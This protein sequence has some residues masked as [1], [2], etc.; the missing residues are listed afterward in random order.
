MNRRRTSPKQDLV[1]AAL[2]GRTDHPTAED[3]YHAL[4]AQG[5]KVSLATVYRALRTLAAE[6]RIAELVGQGPTRF[7]PFTHP[8]SHFRC[9]SC[10][11]LL[12]VET[13]LPTGLLAGLKAQGLKVESYALTLVG[14]CADCQKTKGR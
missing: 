9:R 13:L 6:G 2:A 7:D 10:G 11:R 3:L 1:L 14:L 5:H 12:D 4:H 8:H